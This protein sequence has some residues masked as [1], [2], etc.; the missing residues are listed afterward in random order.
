MN[1]SLG[2]WLFSTLGARGSRA[3]RQPD[4]LPVQGTFNPDQGG[5]A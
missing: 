4:G 2:H 5:G 3:L 1:P